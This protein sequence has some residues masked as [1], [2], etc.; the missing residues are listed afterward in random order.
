MALE[1]IVKKILSEAENEA[2][3]ILDEARKEADK[4]IRENKQSLQD[5]EKKE[6][7][8][9]DQES[10]EYRKRLVQMAD[11]EM[12]KELLSLKQQLVADVFKIVEDRILSLPREDYQEFIAN[13]IIEIIETGTEEIV[14]TE[15]D[16]ERITP[17][18]VEKINSR[19]KEKLREKGQLKIAGETIPIKGGFILRSEK[20]QYNNSV[21]SILKEL[22]EKIEPDIVKKLF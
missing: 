9:I 7:V 4:I 18:F 2:R 21:E 6:K 17:D 16:K 11:L 5:L 12:R 22:R 19:L 20:V 13:K 10:E 15:K 1:D 3:Q 14:L 8:R